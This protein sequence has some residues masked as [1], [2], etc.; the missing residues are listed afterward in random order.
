AVAEK[1]QT[2]KNKKQN[3]TR[4]TKSKKLFQTEVTGLLCI[5]LAV[6][7]IGST[8]IGDGFISKLL[9][10]ACCFLFGFWYFITD[11]VLFFLGILYFMFY[12]CSSFVCICF[13][14]L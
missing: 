7:S 13:G 11:V 4:K 10:N 9:E 5:L 12:I 8:F 6:F 1:K 2:S 14:I 3:K